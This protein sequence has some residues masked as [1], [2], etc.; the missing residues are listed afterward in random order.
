MRSISF[1]DIQLPSPP[2]YN[3]ELL[4]NRR[5]ML[6]RRDLPKGCRVF[7]A[8]TAKHRRASS[9]VVVSKLQVADVPPDPPLFPSSR[10]I[11]EITLTVSDEDL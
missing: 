4:R 2:D 1:N 11:P 8:R 5:I 6:R 9:E 3:T 10:L 7:P